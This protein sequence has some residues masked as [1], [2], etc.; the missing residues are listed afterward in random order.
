MPN[1]GVTTSNL[2]L[3]QDTTPQSTILETLP[4][5]TVVVVLDDSNKTTASGWLHVTG[6]DGKTGYVVSRFVE[7]NVPSTKLL[8]SNAPDGHALNVRSSPAIVSNPD[9]RVDQVNAGEVMTP[10]ESDASVTAKVGSLQ[11]QNLWI[12]VL[13]PSGKTGYVAAWLVT[14]APPSATAPIQVQPPTM[15]VTPPV[16]PVQPPVIPV[17][18]PV[19]PIQPT[20]PTGPQQPPPPPATPVTPTTPTDGTTGTQA[21]YIASIPAGAVQIPQGYYDFWNKRQVIGLPDPFDVLPTQLDGK[22]TAGLPVN[23]FGPNSFAFRNWPNFYRNV[24]GM[25]NGLDHI[26]PTGTSLLA[27]ADGVIVGTE[28][29]WP[30]L[31]NSDKCIILWCFMPPSVTNPVDGKRMLSNVLVAYA[32]L[33]DNSIVKRHDVVNA[34]DVIGKSGFPGGQASNPHLHLEVHLLSGDQNLPRKVTRRLLSDYHNVQPFENSAPFNPLLFFS[35]RL[36]RYQ[37]YQGMKIGFNGGPAYPTTQDLNNAK[38]SLSAWVQAGLA[39]D[40]FAVANYQYQYSPQLVIWE[41]PSLPWPNGIFDLPTLIKRID[42]YS[43]MPF[44]PYPADFLGTPV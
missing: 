10:L 25:H 23:G 5:G 35:E 22:A 16:I 33:S 42:T 20:V 38:P 39:L 37:V 12:Q 29:D 15:P 30:F 9:N 8:V 34:G 3:R 21:A 17:T 40:F 18:P 7:I 32:H 14:Y 1:S 44:I 13:T 31:G 41:Q 6:P 2:N 24:D 4:Q 28:H 11:I 26:L 36:V 19:T 27:V 43:P